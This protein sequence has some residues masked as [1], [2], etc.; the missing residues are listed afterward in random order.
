M[1]IIPKQNIQSGDRPA[2]SD[3]FILANN[4][5]ATSSQMFFESFTD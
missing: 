4:V 5:R 1:C 3:A 2:F